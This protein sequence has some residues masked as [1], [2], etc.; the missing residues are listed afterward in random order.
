[1]LWQKSDNTAFQ[2]S[3][4]LYEIIYFIYKFDHFTDFNIL[5]VSQTSSPDFGLF[6]VLDFKSGDNIEVGNAIRVLKN[7]LNRQ[8]QD[9][10]TNFVGI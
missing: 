7:Q 10:L 2:K 6:E 8:E 5:T 4:S 3:N 9:K 1:M